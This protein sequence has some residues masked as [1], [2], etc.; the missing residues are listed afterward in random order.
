MNWPAAFCWSK[1][2]PEAGF[3]LDQIIRWKELQRSLSAGRF[4]WGVGGIPG[5]EKQDAFI[6]TVDGPKVLFC[7]Q[8]GEAKA[9]YKNPS[10][11]FLWTHY[12]DRT[13]HEIELPRFAA[14]TSKAGASRHYALVCK[15]EYPISVRTNISFD[16]G[17]FGNFQGSPNIANQQPAPII[18]ENKSGHPKRLYSRGFWAD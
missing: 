12:M 13:G 3:T 15:L 9:E 11:T 16:I 4:F 17:L 2:G 5:R 1:I 14:V 18:E 6:R 8:L 10:A 7:E